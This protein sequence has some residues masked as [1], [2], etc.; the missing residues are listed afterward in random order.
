[1]RGVQANTMPNFQDGFLQGSQT[2]ARREE[3]ESKRS[4]LVMCPCL[5]CIRPDSPLVWL[6]GRLVS[7]HEQTRASPGSGTRAV[8]QRHS[9]VQMSG[10]LRHCSGT[11]S[12]PLHS[13]S[14]GVRS[15]ETHR[16]YLPSSQLPPAL[17]QP[18]S[19]PLLSHDPICME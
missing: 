2:P 3:K 15:P 7:R 1:M 4:E 17:T 10:L 19:S 13:H 11:Y 9:G 18:S 5:T 12:G 16:P 14:W 6:V 8:M